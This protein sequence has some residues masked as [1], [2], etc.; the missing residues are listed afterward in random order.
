MTC[1]NQGIMHAA[2]KMGGEPLCRNRKAHMSTTL[3]EFRAYPKQCKR[4]AGKVAKIDAIK[5]K[6][7]T[8]QRTT[9]AAEP[10]EG[11]VMFT[12]ENGTLW[13]YRRSAERRGHAHRVFVYLHDFRAHLTSLYIETMLAA[14]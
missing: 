10:L 9:P 1:N 6:R 11:N 7:E 13:N 5:R 14:R 12:D 4:C 2:G 8:A 3:E